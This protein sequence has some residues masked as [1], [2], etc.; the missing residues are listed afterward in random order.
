MRHSKKFAPQKIPVFNTINCILNCNRNY[1]LTSPCGYIYLPILIAVKIRI[2]KSI[3]IILLIAKI[4]HGNKTQKTH[5]S[6]FQ[7]CG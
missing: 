7:S 2:Y 3:I 6:C 4:H 1:S 5:W